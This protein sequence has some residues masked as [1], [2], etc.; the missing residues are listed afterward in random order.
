MSPS[1]ILMCEQHMVTLGLNVLLLGWAWDL[2]L[3]ALS[4]PLLLLNHLCE[5]RKE[6]SDIVN[7]QMAIRIDV[8][9]CCI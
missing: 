6:K 2:L 9:I 5:K 1:S 8:E 7:E 3:W 4:V